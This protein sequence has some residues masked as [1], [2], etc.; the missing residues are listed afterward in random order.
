MTQD[1]ELSL[2]LKRFF[3]TV[4]GKRFDD[5]K[6]SEVFELVLDYILLFDLAKEGSVRLAEHFGSVSAAFEAPVESIAA[7]LDGNELAAHFFKLTFALGSYY[8][9]DK[10]NGGKR[11]SDIDD[12]AE[13]C[14]HRFSSDRRELYCV[15]MVDA[16]MK[17]LGLEILAEGKACETEL[18]L[19]MIGRAVFAYEANGFILIHNHPFGIPYPS[20][21]DENT[22]K[23]VLELFSKFNKK[24]VEHILISENSYVPILQKMR[25]D[26]SILL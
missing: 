17:M 15:L 1:K 20:E 24:L 14:I 18:D 8:R 9:I 5:I 12:V 19:E 2:R 7:D 16:N 23:T 21:R 22:T 6:P 25:R 3:E 26:G 4:N 13:Y 10:I 11:F